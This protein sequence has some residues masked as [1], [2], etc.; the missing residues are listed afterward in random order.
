MNALRK[1]NCTGCHFNTKNK[2][3]NRAVVLLTEIEV[4]K[5]RRMRK[6]I[7]D[8]QH[9]MQAHKPKMPLGMCSV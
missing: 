9:G 7:Q 8:L 2:T 5:E 3:L 4:N 6:A 1:V